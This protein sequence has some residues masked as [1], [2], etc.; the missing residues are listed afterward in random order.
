MMN[1]Q[2]TSGTENGSGNNNLNPQMNQE[3]FSS[4]ERP[5]INSILNENSNQFGKETTVVEADNNASS[6][7]LSAPSTINDSSTPTVETI[8]QNG[9]EAVNN[10]LSNPTPIVSSTINDS[11][12]PTVETIPQNGVQNVN[13][14]LSNPTSVVSSTIN[15]SSTPTVETIPQNEVQNVNNNETVT[16]TEQTVYNN[17]A[18][19]QMN[20]MSNAVNSTV[21]EKQISP[22]FN[23]D[24]FNAIPEPPIF[25]EESNKKTKAKLDK[26][27]L[28]IILIFILISAIGFGVYYFLTTA[29]L[30][31]SGTLTTNDLTFEL[32]QTLSQNIEDY[33]TITGFKKEDCTLDLSNVDTTTVS[34][35]KYYVSCGNEKKEGTIIID[36]TVVPQLVLNDL[37]VLPNTEIKPEDFVEQ[38]IDASK[39]TFKFNG[40]YQALTKNVGE[41]DI[42]IEAS[43]AFNNKSVSTAKLSVTL[44]APVKYLTCT[45]KEM[46]FDNDKAKYVDS[47]KIGIDANNNFLLANRITKFNYQDSESYQE[48]IQIYEK[49]IGI[50]NI[51]GDESFSL[52]T[53]TITLKSSKTLKDIEN[54]LNGTLSKNMSLFSIYMEGYGYSCK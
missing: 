31:V 52:A 25:E 30:S 3:N 38:C 5:N 1:N 17:P 54:D 46:S 7:T 29:K 28:I 45:S 26:K 41:Y 37:I 43:D 23:N 21:Y 27:I 49:S 2:N 9:V 53:N 40:D 11:S 14:N 35:Y 44:N 20:G 39:C 10:N 51:I 12:T 19:N 47:Y 24:N 36:D 4:S 16:E 50:Q 18:V 48:A 32:G 8:P 13:N 15:D 42:E 6:Q 22:T 33:A 34:T